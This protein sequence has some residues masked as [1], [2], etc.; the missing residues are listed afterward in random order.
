[1]AEGLT[2]LAYLRWGGSALLVFGMLGFIL[3]AEWGTASFTLDVGQ[4]IGRTAVAATALAGLRGNTSWQRRLAVGIGALL[5][6]A[7]LW[8]FLSTRHPPATV[9]ELAYLG[10]PA[11]SA[12][13]LAL[14]AWGTYVALRPPARNQAGPASGGLPS[15]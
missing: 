5:L 12:L 9:F 7:G 11:D 6:L 8:G 4:S 14:G 10:V 13:H 15:A 3:P 2:P 1:M